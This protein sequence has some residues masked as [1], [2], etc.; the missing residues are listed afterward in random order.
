MSAPAVTSP[1]GPG[2]RTS[3]PLNDDSQI[4]QPPLHPS[5]HLEQIPDMGTTLLDRLNVPV[6]SSAF[7]L[8]KFIIFSSPI[9]YV[10]ITVY[11]NLLP[12]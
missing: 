7:G 3:R 1:K 4:S 5:T 10:L 11:G 8:L 6:D 9:F 12:H 2:Y